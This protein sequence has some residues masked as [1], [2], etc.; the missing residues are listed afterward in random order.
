MNEPPARAE[1][2][3]H[4]V[5]PRA[6]REILAEVRDQALSAFSG[7]FFDGDSVVDSPPVVKVGISE[8]GTVHISAQRVEPSLLAEVTLFLRSDFNA[9]AECCYH[10]QGHCEI[11]RLDA[12]PHIQ[13]EFVV[14]LEVGENGTLAI[15][16]T[17][18]RTELAHAI[19]AF[20][21]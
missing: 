1:L 10:L 11:A 7:P 18:L 3:T 5:N 21:A 14:P 20:R 6:V 17:A 9:S 4:T 16:V 12:E 2:E 15:D 13:R 8:S 19:R